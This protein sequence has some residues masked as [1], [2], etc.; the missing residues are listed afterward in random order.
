MIYRP[1]HFRF[2]EIF[3]AGKFLVDLLHSFCRSS[4]PVKV[5]WITIFTINSQDDKILIYRIV[6]LFNFRNFK[7]WNFWIWIWNF[8]SRFIQSYW[9]WL[10]DLLTKLIIIWRTITPVI[11]RLDIFWPDKFTKIFE[12]SFLSKFISKRVSVFTRFWPIPKCNCWFSTSISW[13]VACLAGNRW[14]MIV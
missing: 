2:D 9:L 3:R 11:F 4:C 13:Y 12:I 10:F 6:W 8:S 5:I 7:G 14:W 1:V